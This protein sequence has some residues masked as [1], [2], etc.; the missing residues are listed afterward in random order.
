EWEYVVRRFTKLHGANLSLDLIEKRHVVAYKDQM[1]EQ[2]AAPA[3]INK[4][5]AA[6]GS[7]FQLAVDNDLCVRNVARGVSVRGK[8]VQEESRLPYDTEHLNLIFA[9]SVYSKGLRPTAGGAE[10]AFWLPLLALFTG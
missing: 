5:L 2:G 8:K 9:S 4:H 3:T 10:A 7:L 1:L 6:L